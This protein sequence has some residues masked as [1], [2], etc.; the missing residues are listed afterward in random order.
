MTERSR[1]SFLF[2]LTVLN[3]DYKMDV[4]KRAEHAVAKLAREEWI[5]LR[6]CIDKC[7]SAAIT[8]ERN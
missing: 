4:L 8:F 7:L 6:Q 5:K 3:V 1:K 2:E